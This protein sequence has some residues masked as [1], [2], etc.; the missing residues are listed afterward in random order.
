METLRIHLFGKLQIERGAQ[1]LA[2]LTARKAQELLCYLA[3]HRDRPHAREALADVLW[4]E[5]AAAQ[6][7]KGLR[8]TLWLLHSALEGDADQPAAPALL[9]DPEWVQL[10]AAAQPW[11]DVAAL[12]RAFAAVRDIPGAE[13]DPPAAQELRAAAQLYRADLLEGCYND[14]CLFERER[15]QS[16]YLGMLDRLMDYAECCGEYDAGIGYGTTILRYDAAREHTH[17]RLMRLHYAAGNRT[18]ALRQFERC[19][20]ALREEL[21]AQ[22]ARQTLDLRDHI[23]ADDLQPAGLPLERAAGSGADAFSYL[24]ALQQLLAAAQR[25]L[26]GRIDAGDHSPHRS[27]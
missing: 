1:A 6:A 15:L 9:I 3:L 5:A 18:A 7:R 13:L 10:N 26:P 8:Q 12:E 14:W 23:L 19:A 4:G 2:G 27:P 24:H 25:R 17:R 21:G 16:M 20:A 11:I 22:P